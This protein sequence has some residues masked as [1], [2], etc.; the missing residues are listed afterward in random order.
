MNPPAKRSYGTP[1]LRSQTLVVLYHQ[2]LPPGSARM[3]QKAKIAQVWGIS[4]GENFSDQVRAEGG[5]SQGVGIPG[6]AGPH[7]IFEATS[8]WRPV[9]PR[10]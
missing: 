4:R 9:S 8:R 3:L 10:L 6:I 1:R 7:P 2:Y 5:N